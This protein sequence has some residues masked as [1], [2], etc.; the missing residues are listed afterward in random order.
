M[1]TLEEFLFPWSI[2]LIIG[3]GALLFVLLFAALSKKPEHFAGL[4]IVQFFAISA[5]VVTFILAISYI[6]IDGIYPNFPITTGEMTIQNQTQWMLNIGGVEKDESQMQ[7]GLQIPI[8]IIVAGILGSYIRYLYIGI[9]EF[10]DNHFKKISELNI[11]YINM[12]KKKS[13]LKK[14][15]LDFSQVPAEKNTINMFKE[16][17]SGISSEHDESVAK[18]KELY[19]NLRMEEV[20]H[21]LQT[22]GFIFLAPLL[23][24]SSWLMLILSGTDNHYTFALVGFSVGLGTERIINS[25]KGFLEDKHPS[26]NQKSDDGKTDDG[27]TDDG[28]TDDGKTDDG[29]T[30]DG[31]TEEPKIKNST[32]ASIFVVLKSGGVVGINSID[33][34]T[35]ITGISDSSKIEKTTIANLLGSPKCNTEQYWTSPDNSTRIR[36]KNIT[37]DHSC[38]LYR[39]HL[40]LN[41]KHHE[42]PKDNNSVIEGVKPVES[43]A[44][45]ACKC[46]RAI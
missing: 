46:G 21:T 8:Y 18:V 12:D 32:I 31:K 7:G 30:D 29:K 38:F 33:E 2:L 41:G 14:M 17:K 13:A 19:I 43:V 6:P 45:Y 1:S 35:K 24:V 25:M 36:C 44:F 11:A 9:K 20:H 26:K 39:H 4:A 42:E 3:G 15:D 10:K 16:Q 22:L 37:C 27:K 5:I 34:F 23:A 28:K 40:D